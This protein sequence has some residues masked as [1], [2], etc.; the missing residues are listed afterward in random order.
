[1]CI[2][3]R[4]QICDLKFMLS[5]QL[6]VGSCLLSVRQ[7]NLNKI[8]I[9]FPHPSVVSGVLTDCALVRGMFLIFCEMSSSWV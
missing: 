9:W 3:V 5:S 8:E 1:M 7:M 4:K 2:G 6:T